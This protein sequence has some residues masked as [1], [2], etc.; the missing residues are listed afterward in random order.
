MSE[1]TPER[2][3]RLKEFHDAMLAKL[4]L[5]ENVAKSDWRDEPPMDLY[6]KLHRELGEYLWAH[7]NLPIAF[8]EM[9]DVAN[10]AFMI[11]DVEKP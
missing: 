9:I 8:D 3:S 10:F 2:E 7:Q 1:I 4:N 11:W 6:W 5:P